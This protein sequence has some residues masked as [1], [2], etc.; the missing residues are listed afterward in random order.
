MNDG[1]TATLTVLQ[2]SWAQTL[3]NTFRLW[4]RP[5]LQSAL[6]WFSTYQ[7][8]PDPLSYCP[9]YIVSNVSLSASSM[10]ASLTLG[11]VTC[12]AYGRDLPELVLLVECQTGK[13][14]RHYVAYTIHVIN[15]L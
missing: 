15:T 3:G 6:T 9:G 1:K 11:G 8:A 10:R 14:T 2:K 5:A 12:N 4:K 13:S 7:V